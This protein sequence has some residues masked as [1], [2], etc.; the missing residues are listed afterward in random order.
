MERITTTFFKG[1][2]LF[3]LNFQAFSQGIHQR[4]LEFYNAQGNADVSFYE[5]IPTTPMVPKDRS[6]CELEKT[7]YGWYPYWGGTSYLNY[8]WSLLSHMSFFSYEVNAVN[9]NALTTHGWS[10]SAAVD[11]ALA[12]GNT[13]V[14]LCVTLFSDHATFLTNATSKQ[15]LISNLISLVS[16]RGAHG[17]NIDFEGLPSSQRTNFANFMVNLA[18]QMHSAIPD[19]EVSTVL[20]SVDWNSVFDFSIMEPAVDQYIIMGYDY[21]YSG[22]SNAGPNDPLYHFGSTYNY[23][24]SKSITY[25]QSIGCPKSKLILGLPYYGRDWPTVNSTIPS[26]TSG[27]GS[28]KTYAVVK[29]NASGFYSPAN[30]VYDEEGVT[31]VYTYVNGT[32]RQCFITQED[33][34]DQRLKHVLRSGIGGIGIWALGY[35]NGYT[36]LWDAIETNLTN[37][38]IDACSGDLFDF[39][40]PLKNYYNY[41]DYTWTIEPENAASILVDFSEFFVELNYDY[42]YIYDGNS[43]AA[44]QIPGSPFTG[45]NS[46]GSFTTSTGAVTFRFTSDVST[47]G[48]GFLATYTCEPFSLPVPNFQLSTTSICEGDSIALEN[49]SEN[50]LSYYW[51]SNEGYFSDQTA[52]NP[53]FYPTSSGMYE[54]QLTATNTQGSES[55]TENVALSILEL[56]IAQA[57]LSQTVLQ[58]PD[59]ATVYF[60]NT[61]LFAAGYSWDFGNGA[62]TSDTNPWCL[63]DEPGDYTIQLIAF[64]D[65][66]PNDTAYYQIHVGM[67]GIVETSNTQIQIFPNPFSESIS[68]IG[69]NLEYAEMYDLTGKRVMAIEDL[70]TKTTIDGLDTLTKGLYLLLVHH[71]GIV[72]QYKIVKK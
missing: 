11:A 32:N 28:S 40:G 26:A 42:L 61:S 46:P 1:F 44:S 55:F 10:T 39:G 4:E 25:Y 72:T 50:A 30:Y 53:Y 67:M 59:D 9:G 58:I 68:V 36:E 49:F 16:A 60:D 33:G 70:S 20:Y 6:G 19:S 54:I 17:V 7:V 65:G 71:D 21:Y 18:N 66:C 22:S 63:Y 31:D 8:Q 57:D 48:S 38:Q 62:T 35:D 51:S 2:I 64:G 37:C 15:T 34:F 69:E 13:K 3:L 5:T 45:T 12:S 41:E 56:P 27:T 23:N 43:T 52:E 29:G 24:L 14:T 47:V